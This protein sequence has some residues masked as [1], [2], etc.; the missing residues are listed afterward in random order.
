MVDDDVGRGVGISNNIG[1]GV[2]QMGY[3]NRYDVGNRG[4]Q[5]GYGGYGGYGYGGSSVVYGQ[6]QHQ[7]TKIW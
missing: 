1:L 4:Y 7:P 2:T 5:G 6:A 3:G